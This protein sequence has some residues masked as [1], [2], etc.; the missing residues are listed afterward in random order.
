MGHSTASCLG[1]A[2][3]SPHIS[4]PSLRADLH[5]QGH[6]LL[7]VAG[8]PVRIAVVVANDTSVG[9]ACLPNFLR[10]CMW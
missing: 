10:T 4:R 2:S 8:V 3:Y 6:L 5:A 7:V 1:S 9:L